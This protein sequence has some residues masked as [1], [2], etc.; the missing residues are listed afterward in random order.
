MGA[1]A[2]FRRELLSARVEPNT[3]NQLRTCPTTV[4]PK[5]D[6][7]FD[8]KPSS[9]ELELSRSLVFQCVLGE[10][11]AWGRYCGGI[12]SG[13]IASWKGAC[14]RGLGSTP[15]A[16]SLRSSC[17]DRHTARLYARSRGRPAGEAAL[18]PI[19]VEELAWNEWSHGVRYG[20][21]SRRR[22]TALPHRRIPW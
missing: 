4:A 1:S 18:E 6:W 16:E 2:C 3:R 19:T 14:R 12:C 17:R 22:R 10:S 15:Q 21:R 8:V 11:C 9:A 7:R 20:G 5:N 13:S